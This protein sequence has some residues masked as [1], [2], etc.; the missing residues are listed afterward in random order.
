[1]AQVWLGDRYA[2]SHTFQGRE[3]DRANIDLPMA[4]A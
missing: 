2:G 4:D 3:T 1:M